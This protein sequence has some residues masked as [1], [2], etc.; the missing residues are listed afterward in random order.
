MKDATLTK[1][2]LLI[3]QKAESHTH[4]KYSLAKINKRSNI[5]DF[6]NRKPNSKIECILCSSARHAPQKCPKVLELL[7]PKVEPNDM[8]IEDPRPITYPR[9]RIMNY[10]FQKYIN[11]HKIAQQSICYLCE[12]NNKH[13]MEDCPKLFEIVTKDKPRKTIV[14]SR[15][16]KYKSLVLFDCTCKRKSQNSNVQFATIANTESKVAQSPQTI[17]SNEDVDII[18]LGSLKDQVPPCQHGMAL[19]DC[20]FS[21][22]EDEYEIWYHTNMKQFTVDAKKGPS[23]K[24]KG[25]IHVNNSSKSLLPHKATTTNFNPNGTSVDEILDTATRE[26]GM[27]VLS[28][29]TSSLQKRL[30]GR[31]NNQLPPIIRY[32]PYHLWKVQ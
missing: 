4:S 30:K 17:D 18:T 23:A 22:C 10:Y 28:M 26:H 32:F 7:Y 21:Q 29:R 2:K 12:T 19:G 14:C 15:C 13:K 16:H 6:L 11:E 20:D 5:I 8:F 27:Y 1:T 3:G 9:V 31:L 25:N 24:K